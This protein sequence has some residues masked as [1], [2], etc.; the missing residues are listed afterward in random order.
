[1]T[2][3]QSTS[4]PPDAALSKDERE[5]SQMAQQS[6]RKVTV[7][8]AARPFPHRHRNKHEATMLQPLWATHPKRG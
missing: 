6:L 2:T 4:F 3:E 8:P 7:L 1:M 5:G